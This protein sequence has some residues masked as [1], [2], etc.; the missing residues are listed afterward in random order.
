MNTTSTNTSLP[1]MLRSNYREAFKVLYRDYF[2]MVEYFILK[3]SGTVTDAEDIFQEVMIVLFNKSH[4]KQF[5]LSCSIKTYIYSVSRNLWLKQL[6]KHSKQV[7]ITDYEKYEAIPLEEEELDEENLN[8][9][10]RALEKL[11]EGCRKI[12]LLFYYQKKNMEEIAREM[13]YTNADNAKNQKYKCLQHLKN[14][15]TIANA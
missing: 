9:V 14:N 12:L 5:A 7:S 2:K 15:I 3:N 6:R 1:E 4:D 13:G 11:G 8:K 10:T